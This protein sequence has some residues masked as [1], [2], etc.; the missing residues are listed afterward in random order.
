ML[1][2]LGNVTGAANVTP[3][4]QLGT[5]ALGT[6]TIQAQ[7]IVIAISGLGLTS[8]L[9]TITPVAKANVTIVG[10]ESQVALSTVLGSMLDDSQSSNFSE[11]TVGKHRF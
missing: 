6:I 3:A 2:R 1:V 10:L 9:G 11:I 8:A 4:G 7:V 5:G